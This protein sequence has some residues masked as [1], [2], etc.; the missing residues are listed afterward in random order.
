MP[1]E[2][3]YFRVLG[4]VVVEHAG[5]VAPIRGSQQRTL[6]SLLILRTGFAVSIEDLVDALWGYEPPRSC[7]VQ[8]Q[9]LVSGL[10]RAL[11]PSVIETSPPGYRLRADCECI[12][13][14]QFESDVAGARLRRSEGHPR[15]AL[16]LLRSALA[17]WRGHAF[18]D[19]PSQRVRQAA[20]GIEAMRLT[21][22]ADRIDLDLALG[23]GGD[24]VPELNRIVDDHP[25]D[26]RFARHLML[27][28]SKADRRLDALAAF[29]TL[30]GQLAEEMGI[31]PS[32]DLQTLHR[33][34]LLGHTAAE[35]SIR[36]IPQQL[37][38]AFSK[39]VG[40]DWLI[41]ELTRF[42]RSGAACPA[43]AITGPGG[44]GKTALAVRLA[45]QVRTA[46][47]DGQLYA[48]LGPETA[49]ESVLARFLHAIGMPPSPAARGL[50]ELQ[51]QY[52]DSLAGRKVLVLLD[53]VADES[54][55]RVLLPQHPGCGAIVTSRRRLTGVQGLRPVPLRVLSADDGI[56][57]LG[58]T[59]GAASTDRAASEIVRLCGGLPLA[60]HIVGARL[61]SRSN[62]AL[63]DM[64]RR[65][66]EARGRLD[67]LELGDVSV[68][69]GI[70]ES[71]AGLSAEHQRLFRRLALQASHRFPWWTA[72]ALVPSDGERLLE[73]LVEVHLVEPAGRDITGP[74][75]H[76]HDLVRL[77]ARELATAEDQQVLPRVTNGWFALAVAADSTFGHWVGL[78]PEPEA[79]WHPPDEVLTA[80]RR[81]ATIWFEEVC[82]DLFHVLDQAGELAWPLAQ[83]MSTY[84]ELRGRY[85]Q[86]VDTLSAGLRAAE[87]CADQQ[88]IA[89]MLGLLMDAEAGR[90]DYA[91]SIDYAARTFAAYQKV[92]SPETAVRDPVDEPGG[93]PLTVGLAAAREAAVR[94]MAG[95]EGDYLSLFE[96]ARRGFH[97]SGAVLLEIWA[98]KYVGL[99]YCR[100]GRFKDAEGCLH[101]AGLLLNQ[102]GDLASV[103]HGGGDMAG[104]A[105]ARGRLEEAEG[106]ARLFSRTRQ[107]RLRP[108][109][110]GQG[111]DHAGRRVPEPRRSEGR[112][113]LLRRGS[114]SVAPAG[115]TGT[116]GPRSARAR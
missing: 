41:K 108:V 54:Q 21:A 27:A 5:V 19:V 33:D 96:T 13:L 18:A 12:D 46:F 95:E 71:Y 32:A 53:D 8:I 16:V 2:E 105:A 110:D 61:A 62:A 48:R 11:P 45:N 25:L 72:C 65:L 75:Y 15:Q 47:P 31:E 56:R 24:L 92:R 68:R 10:R 60:I 111:A 30:R 85:G 99:I 58:A 84:L 94:R 29:R 77:V 67:W 44:I 73:D 93:D 98:L 4:P 66:S 39:L 91:A 17:R 6:L 97:R 83:R 22:L 106:I 112:P 63:E 43:A 64:A 36:M 102:L 23:E 114:G 78:D 86:L 80:V 69:A 88:G 20:T 40:R 76:M 3:L 82:A 7:R 55:L 103:A 1:P 28:L 57:L 81:D 52:R 42:L 26:E 87:R 90:D 107:A 116:G 51:D 100:Q 14:K 49:V 9:G 38:W 37:P 113:R 74:V 89:T 101:R 115:H 104:A 109:G 35:R 50:E 79:R 34:L 70:G 59:A